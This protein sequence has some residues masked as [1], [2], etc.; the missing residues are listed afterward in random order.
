VWSYLRRA[1]GTPARLSVVAFG[2]GVA[3]ILLAF[4]AGAL[5]NAGHLHFS[6]TATETTLF[7]LANG[8]FQYTSF[9][10]GVFLLASG[11][12]ILR[13]GALDQWVGYAGA[14]LGTAAIVGG[15]GTFMDSGSLAQGEVY[16]QVLFFAFLLWVFVVSV[17]LAQ[18]ATAAPARKTAARRKR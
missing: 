13:T 7:Y 17:L 8:V 18:R 4:L 2:G 12:V 16:Q 10:A 14:F 15:L 11:L 9:T 1:E 6:A 5:A 3:T